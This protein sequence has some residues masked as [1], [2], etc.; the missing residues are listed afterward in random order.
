MEEY[1]EPRQKV[2]RVLKTSADSI[3]SPQGSP[4]YFKWR[5]AERTL[6]RMLERPPEAAGGAVMEYKNRDGGP[7][8][9]TIACGARMLAGGEKTTRQ[10]Q[11]SVGIFHVVRGRGRTTIDDVVFEWEQGDYFVVPNWTWHRH[12]NRSGNEEAFL[13]FISD[14]PLLEPFE[15]FRES[16]NVIGAAGWVV[17]LGSFIRKEGKL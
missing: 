8:L 13:F 6:R 12:E 2:E 3:L 14:R 15:L 16:R 17:M 7:A 11:T 9:P 4:W 5:D 10:R 1:S